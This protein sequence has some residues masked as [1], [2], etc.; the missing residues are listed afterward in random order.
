MLAGVESVLRRVIIK[1]GGVIPGWL[2]YG[3]SFG[4]RVLRPIYQ[5]TIGHEIINF[6]TEDGFSIYADPIDSVGSNLC[7]S[8]Q[9][10]DIKEKNIL[11]KYLNSDSIMFDIGANVGIYSLWASRTINNHKNII[12]IEADPETFG[13]LQKNMKA[14]NISSRLI[15]I[16]VGDSEKLLPFY[17]NNDNNLG[18][19]SFL[20]TSH[21]S[22]KL[23]NIE[24][25]ALLDIALEF[26]IKKIDFI[27]IDI[28][29]M[30]YKVMKKFFSDCI[31]LGYPLPKFILI[32]IAGGPKGGDVL[33]VKNI[34][35][36]FDKHF[37]QI[38]YD[39]NNT[40]YRLC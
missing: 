6:E 1:L 39:K 10:Y 15:N 37:Y 4:N 17:V 5:A 8:Y 27:K 31:K 16:G 14:N 26:D 22:R 21:E 23:A 35:K 25:K 30:E 40:L 3:S 11:S 29:G 2:P 13:L 34:R 9:F 36:L 20:C 19:N 38:I 32:E 24:T 12:S 33:H 18:G 28:E 7:F